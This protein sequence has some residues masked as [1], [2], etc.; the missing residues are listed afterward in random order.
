MEK[1]PES[2]LPAKVPALVKDLAPGQVSEPIDTPKGRRF[3]A[4]CGRAAGAADTLPAAEDI[5]RQMEDEQLELVS[6][7]YLIDLHRGAI[8]DIR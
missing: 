6:R 7:R 8:I 2:Q 4:L 1:T 3:F 5:R